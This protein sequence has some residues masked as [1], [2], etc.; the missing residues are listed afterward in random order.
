MNSFLLFVGGAAFGV[1]VTTVLL[2]K[3]ALAQSSEPPKEELD[4]P[5]Q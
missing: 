1:T 3:W 5:S 4:A 2:A